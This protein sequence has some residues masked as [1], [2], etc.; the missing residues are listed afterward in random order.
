M[1]DRRSWLSLSKDVHGAGAFGMGSSPAHVSESLLQLPRMPQ[2]VL[3]TN[4]ETTLLLPLLQCPEHLWATL[5]GFG[6][7]VT[8]S[9][10]IPEPPTLV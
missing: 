10:V 6:Y 4:G 9:G 3:L 2:A 1:S 8:N 7:P 5:K